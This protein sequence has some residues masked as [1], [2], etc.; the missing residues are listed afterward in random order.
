MNKT[1]LYYLGVTALITHELDAVLNTEWRL[2]YVLRSLSD[3]LASGYFVALHFVLIF[4]FF[5][6]GHHRNTKLREGFRFLVALFLVIHGVLHFAL[7]G[8]PMYTFS[9]FGSNLYIYS[10][11]VFGLLYLLESFRKKQRR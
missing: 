8:D 5:Y 4:A 10:A 2:L 9:G 7:S 6:I 1:L 11:S 3:D